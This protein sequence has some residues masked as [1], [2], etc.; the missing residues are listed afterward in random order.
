MKFF[1]TLFFLL[2]VLFPFGQL[3][4]VTLSADGLVLQIN[5]LFIGLIIGWWIF[6]HLLKKERFINPPLGKYIFFFFIIGLA[7]ILLNLPHWGFR[8]S[9][10]LYLI[11]W[12]VYAGLYF[13]VYEMVKKKEITRQWVTSGLIAVGIVVGIL[14]LLQYFLYPDLRNLYYLG[15]DPH[16]YRVFSTFFDPAFTGAIL[17]LTLILLAINKRR[18]W[19]WVGAIVVYIAFALTYSRSSYLAFLAGMGTIAY[20]KKSPKFFL[21]VALI[22]ILTLVV[23]PKREDHIGSDLARQESSLARIINWK[24]NLQIIKDNPIFGVGFNNYRQVQGRYGFLEETGVVSH[25]GGG[26]DSSLLFVWATTGILGLAAYLW[27]GWKMIKLIIYNLQFTINLVLVSSIA[28]LF[29]HSFFSNSLFYP[30]IMEWVWILAALASVN[31]AKPLPG[32]T[33]YQVEPR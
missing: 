32:G 28:A 31:K 10:S 29:L 24:Q 14:G 4:R 17:V 23:L 15:W 2:L 25:A 18:W 11:R 5:D 20:L 16:Y 8:L 12:A 21:A 22:F 7:S 33:S 27:L 9:G 6:W 30:W 3:G 19:F 1:K 13:F 26:A